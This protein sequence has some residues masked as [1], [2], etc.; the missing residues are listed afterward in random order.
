MPKYSLYVVQLK[1]TVLQRSQFC[2][3]NVGYVDGKPCVYV[4]HSAKEPE[5]RF[6]QH[7]EGG[8][9]AS[10]W[11]KRYGRRLMGWAF[12]DLPVFDTREDAKQAEAEYAQ[13]LRSRGWSVWQN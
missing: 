4:G 9:F 3:E 5:E 2:K 7:M 8:P 10:P 1:R 13:E 11:V 12:T 6:R